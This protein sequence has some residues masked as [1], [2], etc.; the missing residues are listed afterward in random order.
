MLAGAL[1]GRADHP[2]LRIEPLGTADP[3]PRFVSCAHESRSLPVSTKVGCRLAGALCRQGRIRRAGGTRHPPWGPRLHRFGR[4]RAPVARPG[5]R[6]PHQP[7]RRRDRAHHDAGPRA[8][9][10]APRSRALPPQRLLR[11]RQR[12]RGRRT[13]AGR[14][15]ADLPLRDRGAVPHRRVAD[16]RGPDPGDAARRARLLQPR[17]LASTS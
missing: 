8:L 14:L 10:R 5:A 15:H 3:W 1:T 12:A 7:R 4:G 17:R 11:R 13:R 9:C 2:A 16:R 6:R